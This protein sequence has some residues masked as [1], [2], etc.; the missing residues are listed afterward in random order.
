M[1]LQWNFGVGRKTLCF[2]WLLFAY[3]RTTRGIVADKMICQGP[4]GRADV[5]SEENYD[6]NY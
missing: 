4:R 6:N 5:G 1:D 2:Q 3:T